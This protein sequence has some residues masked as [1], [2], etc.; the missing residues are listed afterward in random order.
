MTEGEDAP[1]EASCGACAPGQAEGCYEAPSSAGQDGSKVSLHVPAAPVDR[2]IGTLRP[3]LNGDVTRA[4][5]PPGLRASMEQAG[6]V[7]VHEHG[8]R[9]LPRGGAGRLVPRQRPRPI[10]RGKDRWEWC[11]DWSGHDYYGKLAAGPRRFATRRTRTIATTVPSR[12]RP[13]M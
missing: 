7:P 6:Q 4:R 12:V 5:T 2:P 8:G 1:H 3:I 9:R 10:R 11:G 13:S